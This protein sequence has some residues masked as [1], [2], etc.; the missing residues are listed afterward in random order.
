MYSADIK[1]RRRDE[2]FEGVGDKTRE[3]ELH[4][5]VC[6]D[7]QDKV[8]HLVCCGVDINKKNLNDWTPIHRAVCCFNMNMV[9]LLV[10]HGA[11]VNGRQK[12]GETLIHRAVLNCHEDM[13]KLL[14][15]LGADVNQKDCVEE[16]ALHKAA[17]NDLWR[18]V[19]LLLSLNAD[20]LIHNKLGQQ[21]VNVATSEIIITLLQQAENQMSNST[22]KHSVIEY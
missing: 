3:W 18:M 16:T 4:I 14:I 2:Y 20:T 22:L 15:S 21:A 6:H 13:L 17:R 8:K 19:P 5:A 9:K 12:F 7:N 1:L 11:N 10:S